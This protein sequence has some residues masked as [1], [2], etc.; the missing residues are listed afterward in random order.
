MSSA[1]RES[2]LLV[3]LR[4]ER[5]RVCRYRLGP[6]TVTAPTHAA[7]T[8]RDD[9]ST[10]RRR[11]IDRRLLVDLG[12]GT[13]VIAALALPLVVSSNA[14]WADWGNHLY[15]IDQQTRWVRSD[16]LPTYFLHSVESG[17]F[18]PHYMFYGGTLYAVTGWLGVVLG[19]VNA[20]RLTFVMAFGACYFGTLWVARQLG[21]RGLLAHI[22]ATVAVSGSYYLTKA[23]DDGGWL[24]V[25]ATSMIPLVVGSTLS[26]V[27][28]KR[29]PL[30][31]ATLLVASTFLL[32][33]SHNI[34]LVFGL[35]F[36]AVVTVT[37]LVVFR[38]CITRALV[39]RFSLV[40]ALIALSAALN[41]WFLVPLA[42]YAHLTVVGRD[43]EQQFDFFDNIVRSFNSWRVVFNPLRSY[44]ILHIPNEHRFYLQAPVY[45]LVWLTCLGVFVWFRR[46]RS[47][48]RTMYSALIVLLGVIFTLILWQGIWDVMPS[49][50]KVIQSRPRLHTYVNYAVVALVIVGLLLLARERRPRAWLLTLLLATAT[51][52][53]FAIWQVWRSPTYYPIGELTKASDRLPLIEYRNC[54]APCPS[55]EADYRMPGDIGGPLDQLNIDVASA[56]TGE[57]LVRVPNGGPYVSNIAW[58]PT[59]ELEG[60]ARI[61]GATTEGW[62]VIAP[63]S[64][65]GEPTSAVQVR[66]RPKATGP[67]I[68]GR[69][70]SAVAAATLLIWL[71]LVVVL[72]AR[73]KRRDVSA[74][75]RT[76]V[77]A[78][79]EARTRA[80]HSSGT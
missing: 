60:P 18:Y 69:V 77:S 71:L 56:R 40:G 11:A 45:V 80:A 19:S 47:T 50:L 26:I 64:R 12:I 54:R 73:R 42:R 78:L 44:P 70:L 59:I 15:L 10:S 24:E 36:L 33:G 28:S 1:R 27:R 79:T 41:G 68:V 22:P 14:F 46:R 75:A 65:S 74:Q 2:V 23:Y 66:L 43:P 5:R 67:V 57:V 6:V 16:L 29:V 31:S 20:Y 25:V 62:A 76:S 58:S 32:T 38:A 9:R 21:V 4:P 39:K 48:T 13:S 7:P 55:T 8:R 37:A 51:T 53:G 49:A 34:T 63:T 52:L 72:R 17:V 30:I 61:V 35:F 3:A